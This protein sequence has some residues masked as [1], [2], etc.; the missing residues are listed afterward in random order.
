VIDLARPVTNLIDVYAN[1]ALV[2]SREVTAAGLLEPRRLEHSARM[3]GHELDRTD[4]D[5]RLLDTVVG[6]ANTASRQAG[7]LAIGVED[8]A[9]I[10]DE[11]LATCR[12]RPRRAAE[13]GPAL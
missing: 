11:H 7:D 5:V 13:K 12:T 2:A 1:A 9:P 8:A 6:R 4:E 10:A 3:A